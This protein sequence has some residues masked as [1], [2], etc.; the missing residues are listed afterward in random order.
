MFWNYFQH[1]QRPSEMPVI[2][3]YMLFRKGIRPMWE[4][5]NNASGGKWILRLKKGVVDRLWENLVN[6]F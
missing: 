4:D 2:S 5:E 1:L 6:Y 3:D